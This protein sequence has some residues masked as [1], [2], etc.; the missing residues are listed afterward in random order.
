MHNL[1]RLVPALEAAHRRDGSLGLARL[2][3]RLGLL[4][5]LPAQPRRKPHRPDHPHRLLD[6]PVV[7]H[8]PQLPVLDVR[9]S[10]QRVHQQPV[11]PLV[12][13]Q[14]HRIRR[15]VAPPQVVQDR[16]RLHH[17]L[18]RLGILHRQ[19]APHLHPH[20]ARK[21]HKQGLHRLHL[22]GNDSPS[23]LYFFLQ[24]ESIP[25]NRHIQV[26]H[27]RAAGQVAHRAPHQKHRQPLGAGDLA[28][29]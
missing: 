23:L 19:R 13:R 10:V 3:A 16:R 5:H 29:L 27:R 2:V 25:L 12:Q 9:H 21:A 20:V 8:Q 7:A 11:R 4:F 1:F 22:P 17:R 6:E 15:K 26:A 18:A 28:Y 24:L 14:R